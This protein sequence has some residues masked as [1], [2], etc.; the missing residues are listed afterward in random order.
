[1]PFQLKVGEAKRMGPLGPP[2][3]SG[4]GGMVESIVSQYH[5]D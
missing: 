3:M 2:V 1:M 5:E 4:A